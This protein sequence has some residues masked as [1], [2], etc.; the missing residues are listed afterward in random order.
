[1]MLKLENKISSWAALGAKID[2]L[3]NSEAADPQF[4]QV[5]IQAESQ[6][7]WFTKEQVLFALKAWSELLNSDNLNNWLSSY[8]IVDSTDKTVAVIAAGNI[9]L[10]GLHDALAVLLS[11]NKLQLKLSSNDQVLLPYLLD[12]LIEIEPAWQDRIEIRKDEVKDYNAV[13]ATGSDN[14]ARYFE[15]YF[16]GK[17]HIIRRNRNSAA[18]LN[19]SE[20]EQELSGLA[21]DIFRYYGLGCRSV[22]KLYVP[23]NY[24][25][26]LLFKAVYK[27]KH[28]LEHKKYENNY[29]YNKAVFLMSQ[30]KFLEN[31]FFMIKED[32]RMS[33][34]IASVFYEYYDDIDELND[35]LREIQDQ[36]QCVVSSAGI[37]NSLAF[38][39]S[40]NPGLSDYADGVD[41]LEF[42]LK[43]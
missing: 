22:S 16:K 23:H 39:S 24:D 43:L 32:E 38:G 20:S 12:L 4:N 11:G 27:W 21:D 29:D 9:P 6:N 28:L 8:D 3:C 18:V 30:F 25:F 13:I 2:S 10:V 40:Q 36:I 1:M 42:L 15:H 5:L 37:A 7:G 26:D 41:T 33:S 14:T 34:P 31:G 35:Q 17:P 19:G